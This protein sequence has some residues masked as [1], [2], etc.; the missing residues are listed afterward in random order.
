MAISGSFEMRLI[1][2][3]EMAAAEVIVV[4]YISELQNNISL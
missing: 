3:K 4:I 1:N 2:I